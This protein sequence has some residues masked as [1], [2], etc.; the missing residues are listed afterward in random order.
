M[1]NGIMAKGINNKS[2][3]TEFLLNLLQSICCNKNLFK[4]ILGGS[5]PPPYI[6]LLSL[7]PY[8]FSRKAAGASP[9]PTAKARHYL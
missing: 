3:G 7:P 4:F 6:H 1:A 2:S 8:F 9:R 5:K